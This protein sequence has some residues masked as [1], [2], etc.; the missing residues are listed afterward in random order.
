MSLFS[1]IEKTIERG[2]RKFTEKAFGPADSGEL[3][4]VHRSILEEI[5][6]KVQT[7]QRGR[8]VFP[9][10]HVTV[11]L[12]SADADR[13]AL[14]LAAFAHEQRLERD[15]REVLTAAGCDLPKQFTVEVETAAEGERR[16]ECSVRETPAAPLAATAA[17]GRLIVTKGVAQAAEFELTKARLNLGRLEEITDSEQRIVRRNDIA[18]MEGDDQANATVSRQHAHIERDAEAG[19]YRIADDGSEYGTRIFRDGRSI[20]VPK[21]SRRGERL[22]AGDE[23]YLGRA[24]LRFEA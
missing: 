18:F 21:G 6:G 10:S 12:P 5:E 8:R 17:R 2:F 3:L 24:C 11:Y 20:E 13:R 14:Y 23:I 19:G 1:E 7:V 15:I 16:I 9:Y 4:L 22:R